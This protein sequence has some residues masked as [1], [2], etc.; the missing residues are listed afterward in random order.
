MIAS[1][2]GVLLRVRYQPGNR[3]TLLYPYIIMEMEWAGEGPKIRI[4]GVDDFPDNMCVPLHRFSQHLAVAC[5]VN[6]L[7]DV[8]NEPVVM[9]CEKK[10]KKSKTAI[11][12][13]I[14]FERSRSYVDVDECM[15]K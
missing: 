10:T 13:G 3:Y 12:R 14:T 6:R 7:M 11:L 8:K 2:Q 15:A 9:H 4:L 1:F 5:G